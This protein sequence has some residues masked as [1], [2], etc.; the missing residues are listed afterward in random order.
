MKREE[1]KIQEAIIRRFNELV[2]YK[3]LHQ[4]CVLYSNRNEN[5]IGGSKG[6]ASGAR[7]KRL[8]RLAGVPDLT[9]IYRGATG[10]NIAYIEIKTPSQHRTKKGLESK[11]R[12]MND[13][14]IEFLQKFIEP[15]G[16]KFTVCS[17]VNDFENFIRIVHLMG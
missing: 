8:G 14:Q 11:S 7:F 5:N 1:E 4:Y 15:L 9:L 10:A 16:I 3:Q 6:V 13:A 17:S 2:Y 12:G